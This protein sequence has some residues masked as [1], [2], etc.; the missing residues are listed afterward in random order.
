MHISLL[1]YMNKKLTLIWNTVADGGGA[2]MKAAAR[3]GDNDDGN[4][5][6]DLVVRCSNVQRNIFNEK[7]CRISYHPSACSSVPL[8]DPNDFFKSNMQ[9]PGD[10][11]DGLW[12]YTPP[13]AGPDNGGVIGKSTPEMIVSFFHGLSYVLMRSTESLWV[14][15]RNIAKPHRRRSLRRNQSKSWTRTD[16]LRSAEDNRLDW[17]CACSPRSTLSKIG[18]WIE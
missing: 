15:E 3:S 12:K 16:W 11:V 4:P 5:D 9:N 6:T 8:P 10:D 7:K 1:L 14:R 2:T 13:Y 18:V 17:S